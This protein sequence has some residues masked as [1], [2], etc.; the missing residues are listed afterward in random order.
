MLHVYSTLLHSV[1]VSALRAAAIM[2]K[3]KRISLKLRQETLVRAISS[4]RQLLTLTTLSLQG[5]GIRKI[6]IPV[7]FGLQAIP[8]TLILMV[9]SGKLDRSP[10]FLL[11]KE[12]R[13]P[14]LMVEPLSNLIS[15]KSN[16]HF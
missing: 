8:I 1:I 7:K 3:I 15:E 9:E 6:P 5:S 16:G 2:L 4:E 12:Q 14:Y 11:G 13:L 10:V